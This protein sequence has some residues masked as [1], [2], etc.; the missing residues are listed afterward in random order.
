MTHHMR[1]S[2]LPTKRLVVC[3]CCT[4]H[5]ILGAYIGSLLRWPDHAHKHHLRRMQ[6]FQTW[7]DCTACLCA[8]LQWQVYV[9]KGSWEPSYRKPAIGAVSVVVSWLALLLVALL[10]SR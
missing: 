8:P 10:V 7:L 5:V 2:K 9:W 4:A 6:A 1:S 3:N